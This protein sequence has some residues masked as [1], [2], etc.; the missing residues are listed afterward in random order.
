M[1]FCDAQQFVIYVCDVCMF[2]VFP[3]CVCTCTYVYVREREH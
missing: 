1:M 2:T 3:S